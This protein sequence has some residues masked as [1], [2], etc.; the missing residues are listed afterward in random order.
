MYLLETGFTC[1]KMACMLVGSCRTIHRRF[2]ENGLSV[3]SKY[4]SLV[5]SDLDVLVSE[6]RN[7]FPNYGYT[8]TST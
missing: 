2:Q 6:I 5:D 3:S 1:L 7:D 4:S 8:R